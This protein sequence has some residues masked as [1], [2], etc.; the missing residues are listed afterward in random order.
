MSTA[1]KIAMPSQNA[2][3]DILQQLSTQ[4]EKLSKPNAQGNA[5]HIKLTLEREGKAWLIR[6]TSEESL[7]KVRTRFSGEERAAKGE[8]RE[9]L[10]ALLNELYR[11]GAI[12]GCS[13]VIYHKAEKYVSQYCEDKFQLGAVHMHPVVAETDDCS[14]PESLMRSCC[15]TP[16]PLAAV[17]APA[18]TTATATASSS[19]SSSSSSGVIDLTYDADAFDDAVGE[20]G[21]DIKKRQMQPSSAKKSP[22]KK[23][24]T[25]G[26]SAPRP[27]GGNSNSN[28]KK[29]EQ[30]QQQP[31]VSGKKRSH[32]E[33]LGDSNIESGDCL[34]APPAPIV[35]PACQ[36]TGGPVSSTTTTTSS[37]RDVETAHT[38]KRRRLSIGLPSIKLD[39]FCCGVLTGLLTQVAC[40]RLWNSVFSFQSTP[41]PLLL[42]S[43]TAE[44]GYLVVF[45]SVFG[46]L[47]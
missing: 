44:Q 28:K 39:S 24:T 45:K 2:A 13:V 16:A 30:Q 22:A 6:S 23:T 21:S 7:A 43:G 12:S 9:A 26:P 19:S 14:V 46:F 18:T 15:A 37:D 31:R 38:V 20:T 42:G 25:K 40:F 11:W 17:T 4:I 29:L 3:G 5:W 47:P 33:A 35:G 10:A 8:A 32:Q 34:P 27:V 1:S 41:V 36:S